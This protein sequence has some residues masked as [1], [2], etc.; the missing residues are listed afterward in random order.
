M[1]WI[2]GLR[3]RLRTLLNPGDYDRELDDEMRFHL[4]LDGMQQQDEDRS[5]RRFGNR[6][7]YKEETRRM[8]WLGLFDTLGQDARYAWRSLSRAPSFTL[9]VLVT[10][11]L[12]IGVNAA[13][14]SVLDTLYLRPPAGVAAP[15]GLRR[16]WVQHFNTENGIPVTSQGITYPMFRTIAEASGRPT[17]MA[18]Y[19]IDSDLRLGGTHLGPKVDVA[20]AS[21]NYFPVLG[22]RPALGRFYTADE[23]RLG[24]GAHVVVVGNAFWR[25]HLGGDTAIFGKTIQLD[26]TKYTVI[27][28]APPSFTG[29][30]LEPAD[31]WIPFAS[32]PQPAWLEQPVWESPRMQ[33]FRAFGRLAPRVDVS[34]F[35][36]RAT[37][38][39]RN[40]NRQPDARNRDT[41]TNVFAG[42]IIVARGP[43]KPDQENIISTRLSGVALIVF[44]IACANVIN[45]FLA[46][47]MRRRREIAVR[48]ALGVSRSRLIRLFTVETVLLALLAALTGVLAAWWGGNLLRSLL[49]PDIAWPSSALDGRVV[50]F[51]FSVALFAGLI[52]G[53]VPGLQAS[54]PRLVLALKEGLR[55]GAMHRSLLGTSLV[56]IQA[57]LCVALLMGSA[58]F[59]KSL[60]NV[61]MLDIGYDA[62]QLLF[63]SVNFDPG[64][65]VP[66]AVLESRLVEVSQRLESRP[67]IERVARASFAPMRGFIGT[68]FYFGSDSS[69]SLREFPTTYSVSASYFQ[70]TGMRLL[71]GKVFDDRPGGPKEVVLNETM[72][73]QL[74]PREDPIGQCMR[75][76]RRDGPC[77]TVSGIV[78]TARRDNLIEEPL[79][80][81]YLSLGNF[82]L[83][84]FHGWTVIVRAQAGANNMA[85]AE[86]TAA[87]RGAVPSGYPS[88]KAM[89]ENLESQYRPWRLGAT[90]FTGFGL[91]AVVVALVGIYSTVSY[92]VSQRTHEFGIR[93]ALGARMLDVLRLVVG[94]GLRTVA[95]G[96]G[97][98]V[99]TALAAGRA[100]AAPLY[101]VAPSDPAVILQVSLILLVVAG[102]AALVPA[103]RAARVDPMTALKAE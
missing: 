96:V 6:T 48:L 37:L 1:S 28:V 3:H 73:K 79:P 57:A 65:S 95:I 27:G 19:K 74:W 78:E 15:S 21:S 32:Q 5:R 58:L 50:I 103:W 88:V 83:K 22:V 63:G 66:D 97:L 2:D 30:D 16:I 36:Q 34:A 45:L 52:A 61:Q 10:F 11:A 26:A 56:V 89:T 51:T 38:M 86:L 69:A 77:Y 92:G 53:I 44:L 98:G 75:F 91:L 46:R 31:A 90:L 29:V 70:T 94:E 42:S 39:L 64:Q 41:L 13:T 102:L 62:G 99:V 4:E 67:G 87:L 18:V 84:G 35:E 9:L 12:G 7:Y 76:D 23:D 55:D 24:S 54:K 82:P 85:R 101:G 68:S 20:Y 60:R 49:L 14:F 25:T 33:I 81:Y 72:A 93:I 80:Q 71:R 100:I 40:L 8:T 43:R 47:A 17:D 59:V